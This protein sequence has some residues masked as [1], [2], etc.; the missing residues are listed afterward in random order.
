MLS[1]VANSLY[2]MLRYIER[3]DNLARLI[4]VNELLVLDLGRID[5]RIFET[6]WRPVILATGDQELFDEAYPEATQRDAIHFL[7]EDRSNPNSI[8]SCIASA[9]ENARMVR[10]Q[11]AEDL[12]E[13]LNGLYLFL[14]SPESSRILASD[15]SGYYESIR[16]S[17]FTFHGIAAATTMR[18][19]A[20]DFMDLARHLERADKT[21]RFLDITTYLE[22]RSSDLPVGSDDY[23]LAILRSCGGV[24]A[25][26]S[27]YRGRFSPRN[28]TEFLI[29]SEKFPR[30]VRFCVKRLDASLHSISNSPAGSFADEA[31]RESGQLLSF[32]AYG[33][34][35]DVM[36]VGLHSYLDD[37]QGRLNGIADAIFK[38]YVLFP[39]QVDE[40]PSIP[41]SSL[42][43][44]VKWQMEQQQQ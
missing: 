20:W 2:W 33:S 32:L 5:P 34:C 18:S 23:W 40:R 41:A 3:A 6:L 9:R 29:F 28:I 43:S 7:T 14:N 12:W 21:T 31:E 35:D 22:T 42:S 39:E 27:R 10:D 8:V 19:E 16:R 38:T 11:L 4:E 37:L 24:D 30:S 13:E 26:R 1:R 17:T 44:V 15:P 36:S 25:F